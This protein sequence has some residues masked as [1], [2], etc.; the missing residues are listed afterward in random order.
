MRKAKTD[1]GKLQD[2]SPIKTKTQPSPELGLALAPVM[3]DQVASKD[4]DAESSSILLAI[5]S[6]NKTMTDRF[7]TLEATLASQASLVSLGNRMTEI[8]EANSSYDLRLSQVEQACM[9]MQTENHALRSKV[10]DLEVRSR[11][12][13]IKIVVDRAHRLGRQSAVEDATP[14]A[15]IARIHHFPNLPVEVIKQR[16]A[17]DDVRKRLK[18]AGARVGFIYPARLRVTLGNSEQVF[19]SSQEAVLFAGSLS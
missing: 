15:M 13:N 2:K 17:F 19:T 16:Q 1:C 9:Q 14:S 7:Y 6:M 12:E 3:T 5:E 11:R 8:E 4:T 10:I 18:E